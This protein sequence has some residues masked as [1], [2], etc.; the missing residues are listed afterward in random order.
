MI[1]LQ[2][3]NIIF[4]LQSRGGI[5]KVWSK[6][7]SNLY[8]N[9]NISFLF[10][11]TKFVNNQFRKEINISPQ[12]I[13][14]EK[15]L[16]IFLRQYLRPDN[17]NCDIFHSSYYRLI[18]NKR[19]TKVVVTVH[20]FIYERYNSFLS[21][22]NHI[23]LKRRAMLQADA[24]ICVSEN[25]KKDL[26]FFYPQIFEKKIVDVIYNGVDEE[27][28]EINNSQGF[29]FREKF[30]TNE[31]YLL[32]VGNRGYCKNFDFVLRLMKTNIV[33]NSNL[34]L[35]CIGSQ[36]SK[37]EIAKIKNFNLDEKINFFSNVGSKDLNSFYNN[38][39]CLLMPSIYEGFGIP[40]VEAMKTGCVIWCSNTSSLPEIVGNK[41]PYF[42]DPNDWDSALKS[43]NKIFND[44]LVFVKKKLIKKSKK[45]SWAKS[46]ENTLNLYRKVLNK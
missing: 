16:N 25:T 34:K 46:S 44:D 22:F 31:S 20:D 41:Y 32:Y 14:Y 10:N 8:S 45:F 3:D 13:I 17:L 43:F 1:K 7:I 4:D 30:L 9:S 18:N 35:I 23:F 26:K 12:D 6:Q 21:R 19:K 33:K 2:Y 36:P 15:K 39:F 37:R 27:F 5:S 28:F 40:A 24:I 38:A 11:E 42:F 29:C